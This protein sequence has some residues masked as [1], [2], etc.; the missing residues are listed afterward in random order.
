M[1]C[2]SLCVY[3][4]NVIDSLVT[5]AQKPLDNKKQQDKND[6]YEI[7]SVCVNVRLKRCSSS[8]LRQNTDTCQLFLSLFHGHFQQSFIIFTTDFTSLSGTVFQFFN[9]KHAIKFRKQQRKD[10]HNFLYKVSGWLCFLLDV[11]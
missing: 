7:R 4:V 9:Y 2:V 11:K 5:L 10:F 6:F 1:Y 8:R 3:E